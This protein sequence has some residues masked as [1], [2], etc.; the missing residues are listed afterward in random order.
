[1]ICVQSAFKLCLVKISVLLQDFSKH[2]KMISNLTFKML[3][4]YT[5][6]NCL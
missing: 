6:C 3:I 4:K 5:Q 1:M 2:F